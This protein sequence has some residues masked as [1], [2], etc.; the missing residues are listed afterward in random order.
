LAREQVNSN[1][2]IGLAIR[3]ISQYNQLSSNI[4]NILFKIV[5]Q[6]IGFIGG[7]N[8]A[9]SLIGGLI[10]GGTVSAKQISVFEPNAQRAESLAQKYGIFAAPDNSSLLARSQIVVI[11]VKPQV[12]E[13]VL[14]PLADDFRAAQP[15]IISVVAGIPAQSIERW[16]GES[17]A[18]IRVMPNTPALVGSGASGLFAN[19]M[20]SSA[21]K[22]VAQQLMNT[23][24]VS[25]WVPKETDIDSVTALSGSGPAYFMLFMQSL[26]EAGVAAGLEPETAKILAIATA[27]GAA[28]LV[29]SSDLSLQ[30]LIDNV[31]SPKGTTESAM[32][33]FHASKLPAVVNTAFTAAKI[34]SEELAEELG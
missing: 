4:I 16:L 9:T 18:I 32:Q 6:S 20:V 5:N 14:T 25:A 19:A 7:G 26:I 29:E 27:K 1:K 3:N 8:M 12:L 13:K 30:A 23:V 24:G 10:S 31:T 34:R 33:A 11:A 2:L 28:E 22:T 21:Q 17:F 15:L